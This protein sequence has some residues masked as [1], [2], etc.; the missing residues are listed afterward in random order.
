MA[1]KRAPVAPFSMK[2]LPIV[3]VFRKESVSDGLDAQNLA[4][5]AVSAKNQFSEQILGLVSKLLF[6]LCVNRP[7]HFWGAGHVV[8]A[9]VIVFV[10]FVWFL[11][12]VSVF[13]SS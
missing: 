13:V 8:L 3:S 9:L 7:G 4:G 10:V 12:F 5:S 2:K 6:S 1:P 11:V